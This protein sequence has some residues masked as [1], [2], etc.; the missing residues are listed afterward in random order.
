M[1]DGMSP[2][3]IRATSARGCARI[4]PGA[5]A[6]SKTANRNS[7]HV[8][9]ERSIATFHQFSPYLSR[10][11][12][13]GS[14]RRKRCDEHD[15]CERDSDAGH[16]P[17]NH[18]S[19]NSVSARR[20]A[21]EHHSPPAALASRRTRPGE[22]RWSHALLMRLLRPLPVCRSWKPLRCG[23]SGCRSDHRG[24]VARWFHAEP[25]FTSCAGRFGISVLLLSSSRIVLSSRSSVKQ[26]R[27]DRSQL[28][29][30]GRG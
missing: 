14:V 4:G 29:R 13:R 30:C 12:A 21:G 22:A 26:N 3:S 1:A 19:G 9:L 18:N 27:Q 2:D 25:P 24:Q 15:G 20:N 5:Q 6:S 10:F 16:A 23:P 7:T 11:T 28:V 8:M 17:N